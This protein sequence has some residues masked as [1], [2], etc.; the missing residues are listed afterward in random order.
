MKAENNLSL[1]T[2]RLADRLGMESKALFTWLHDHGWIIRTQDRWELSPI[3]EN[4]GGNYHHSEQYGAYIVWPVSLVTELSSTLNQGQHLSATRL[5]THVGL[6]AHTLNLL[7]RHLGWL[8]KHDNGWLVTPLGKQHG[9]EQRQSKQGLYGVWIYSD[10][11]RDRLQGYA[12]NIHGKALPICLD[13]HRASNSGEQRL[14]NWLY[15]HDVI[16]AF[17]YRLPFGDNQYCTFYVPDCQM[18]IDYS[19]SIDLS[20]SL[21]VQWDKQA[22]FERKQLHYLCLHDEDLD[23]LDKSLREPL[24]SLGASLS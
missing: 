10:A 24:L 22:M 6:D 18:Y 1:S 23:T 5:S 11:L 4:H 20:T 16:H 8:R 15:L 17:H 2:S 13:G 21:S 19:G 3:G 9:G 14:C 12:H 7:L